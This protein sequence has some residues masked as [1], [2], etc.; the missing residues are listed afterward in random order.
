MTEIIKCS[1]KISQY[2]NNIISVTGSCGK[3]TTCKMIYELLKNKYTI[4]KTHEN[5]NSFLG[6]PWCVNNFFNINSDL[7]LIEIGIGAVNEMDKLVK[8]INPN[9]RIITNIT[10]AHLANFNNLKE[11][12]DEKLKFYDTMSENNI[13]IINNDDILLANYKFKPNIKV[14]YCGSKDTDDIQII[15]F[16]LNEDNI[17]SSIHIKINTINQNIINK[18]I[19]FKLNGICKH[20]AINCSLAIGCAIYFNIPLDLIIKTLNIFKL[21]K[22]RGNIIVI[23]NIAYKNF[24][25]LK[26]YFLYYF[27]NIFSK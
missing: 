11:Y 22:N 18:N 16:K 10:E 1:N 12:Q 17:S 2:K 8:M 23:Y 20:N 26:R 3:T 24:F 25:K 15:D 4:D 5:S 13:A 19:K 21:Y 7:W 14:I 27:L 9:I 6:I